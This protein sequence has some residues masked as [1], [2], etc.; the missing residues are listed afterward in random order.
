MFKRV[1]GTMKKTKRDE[2]GRVHAHRTM[3]IM[4]ALRPSKQTGMAWEEKID[5]GRRMSLCLVW[6]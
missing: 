4:F 3:V 2:R 1:T 5:E 6:C